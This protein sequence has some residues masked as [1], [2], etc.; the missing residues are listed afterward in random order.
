MRTSILGIIVSAA[1][2]FAFFG[3]ASPAYTES[4]VIT[5]GG[6]MG[7]GRYA[8]ER[9]QRAGCDVCVRG[10]ASATYSR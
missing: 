6:P 7:A 5:R 9:L 8:G 1:V 4:V 2:G 3:V 10:R